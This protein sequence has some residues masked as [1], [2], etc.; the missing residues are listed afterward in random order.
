MTRA[1]TGSGYTCGADGKWNLTDPYAPECKRVCEDPPGISHGYP[2]GPDYRYPYW[3][4]DTLEADYT[5]TYPYI[6]GDQAIYKCFENFVLV[7][8]NT[9][10]VCRADGSWSLPASKLPQCKPAC[11]TPPL[12]NSSGV[13]ASPN[14]PANSYG[15]SSCYKITAPSGQ[16]MRVLFTHLDLDGRDRDINVL[17]PGTTCEYDNLIIVDGS[18]EDTNENGFCGT[19]RPPPFTSHSNRLTIFLRSEEQIYIN[20]FRLEWMFLSN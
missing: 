14:F 10:S 20:R 5:F 8:E 1:I 16:I 9:T 17:T 11:A 7:G 13:I 15:I 4:Y 12:T 6:V 19:S 18:Y 2:D 3:D